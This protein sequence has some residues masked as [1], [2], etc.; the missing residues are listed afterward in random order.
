MSEGVIANPRSAETA[1]DGDSSSDKTMSLET[2]AEYQWNITDKMGS[3]HRDRYPFSKLDS[4]RR[5]Y[6]EAF[7][8][9]SAAID[10]V[11]SKSALDSLSSIRHL[12]IHKGGRANA[13]YIKACKFSRSS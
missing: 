4:I 10:A 11:L 12:L 13:T 5:A 1:A 7:S 3:V 6:S 2:L 8:K 9:R